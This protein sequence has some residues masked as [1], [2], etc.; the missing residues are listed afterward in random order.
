[1][2]MMRSA[3]GAC[4]IAIC[5]AAGLTGNGAWRHTHAQ[6][7]TPPPAAHQPPHSVEPATGYAGTVF[8]FYA[9]GF[10]DEEPVSY[11][12]NAPDGTVH[13]N[14][15]DYRTDAYQGR[16]DWKWQAP[17]NALSGTWTAVAYGANSHHE[18]VIPFTAQA[19]QPSQPRD[20]LPVPPETQ[21]INPPGVAVEPVTG[22]PGT[23]FSFFASGFGD[24]ETIYFWATDPHGDGIGS[25]GFKIKANQQG[26]GYWNW[27]SPGDA[28]YGRWMMVAQGQ[29]G[30]QRV[31]HFDI[32]D[33]SVPACQDPSIPQPESAVE[34]PSGQA[35]IRFTFYATGFPA[36]KHIKTWAVDPYG[37][38]CEKGQKRVWVNKNGRADWYWASPVDATPGTWTMVAEHEDTGV[39]HEIPFEITR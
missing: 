2:S 39:R 27:K 31:I 32:R 11:W 14:T 15:H 21:P 35:G 25:D 28:M 19:P 1:M 13:A 22:L 29:S 24:G 4:L 10:N 17:H 37:H 38:T 12:F 5:I 23:R 6:E 34:P 26:E 16:A 18:Q 3:I 7:K 8:A 20:D 36:T 33:P 30:L 9:T